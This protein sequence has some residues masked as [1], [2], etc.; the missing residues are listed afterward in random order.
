M[1]GSAM[2]RMQHW[3]MHFVLA[4]YGP[5][6]VYNASQYSDFTIRHN[7]MVPDSVVKGPGSFFSAY[8]LTAVAFRIFYLARIV[9]A[10]WLIAG[11]PLPVAALLVPAVCG[12]N[13]TLLFVVSHNFEGSD[14]HPVERAQ[15][16]DGSVKSTQKAEAW[17]SADC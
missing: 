16:K 11:V 1:M 10:P 5:S 2:H 12:T 13:L 9:I 17:P 3:Y 7:S 4:L 8:W 15:G 14:R 6:I